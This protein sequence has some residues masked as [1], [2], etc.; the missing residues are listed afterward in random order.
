MTVAEAPVFDGLVG[1]APPSPAGPAPADGTGVR[2]PHS[3]PLPRALQTLRFSVRQTEFV[4]R[5]RRELG[6]V[7]LFRGIVDDELDAIT[8]H[9]DHVRSLFTANP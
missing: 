7:F 6:D 2:L 9:P 3:L 1:E 4:F 8:C 5:A